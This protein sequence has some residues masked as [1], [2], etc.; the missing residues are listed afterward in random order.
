MGIIDQMDISRAP[1]LPPL[2]IS[3]LISLSGSVIYLCINSSFNT[4][5]VECNF[6][7]N[8]CGWESVDV[9]GWRLESG[10]SI[11]GSLTGPTVDK[12]N[13]TSAGRLVAMAADSNGI[14]LLSEAGIFHEQ[15]MLH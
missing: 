1:D 2:I 7:D 11:S 14:M 12:T 3:S 15:E 4:V 13:G 8:G 10:D 5:G 6:E 9:N